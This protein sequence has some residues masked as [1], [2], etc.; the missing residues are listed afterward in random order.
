MHII[1]RDIHS[2]DYIIRNHI[3]PHSGD[4]VGYLVLYK[5]IGMIRTTEKHNDEMALLPGSLQH[6]HTRAGHIRCVSRFRLFRL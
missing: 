3:R 4:N 2:S 6:I 5:R 1:E